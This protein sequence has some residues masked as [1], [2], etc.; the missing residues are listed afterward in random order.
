MIVL[1][2]GKRKSGKDYVSDYL[3]SKLCSNG[4]S[5]FL[6]RISAP[7]KEA[8]ATENGLDY[9]AL[10]SSGPY[11]EKYRDDMVRW[12]EEKRRYDSGYFIRLSMQNLTDKQS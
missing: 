1:I 8:Y 9:D 12:G 3:R 7:L 11:K 5:T 6:V 10:L 4:V 2:S